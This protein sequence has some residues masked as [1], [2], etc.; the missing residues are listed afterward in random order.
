VGA[1]IT[2]TAS[3]TTDQGIG[4]HDARAATVG[5]DG[6]TITAQ[7]PCTRQRFDRVEHLIG[8]EDPQHAGTPMTASEAGRNKY[9]R[10]QT[11]IS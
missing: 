7:R 2:K 6:E 8:L 3:A 9:S 10:F 4:R 11:L 1:C 5:E